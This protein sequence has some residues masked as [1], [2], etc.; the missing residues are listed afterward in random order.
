MRTLSAG[1]A[2]WHSQRARRSETE[3]PHGLAP[4]TESASASSS[5][6]LFDLLETVNPY[7]SHPSTHSATAAASGAPSVSSRIA[8]MLPPMPSLPAA[9]VKAAAPYPE[10]PPHR[11]WATS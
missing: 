6:S 10:A 11:A 8:D 1:S 4:P 9:R 7:L 2:P 3:E 5:T